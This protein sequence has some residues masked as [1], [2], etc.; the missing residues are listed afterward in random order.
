MRFVKIKNIASTKTLHEAVFVYGGA[1]A[2][3]GA[4]FALNV[5]LAHMLS[6]ENFGAFSLAIL[7]LG[8]VAELSDFGLNAGFLRFAPYY[9]ERNEVG[10]LTQLVKTV[11]RWRLTMSAIL[12]VGGIIFA[13][14]IAVYIFKQPAITGLLRLS[15]LGVGGVIL[16]GFV[17]TYLQAMQHFTLTSMLQ[18]LKGILRF[19][20]IMILLVCKVTNLYV[21][22]LAYLLIPW[23]LLGMLYH[24]LP[25]NFNTIKVEE[26]VKKKLHS[27]LARY[28]FWITIW[29]FSAIVSSRIDQILISN[30]LDLGQVAIYSVA[31]QFIFIYSL[32]IQSISSVLIPKISKITSRE[33][34]AAYSKKVFKWI[35]P[36]AVLLAFCIYPSQFVVSLIFGEKYAASM[37]L[38]T[39]LSYFTLVNFLAIPLPLI[40][41]VYN[42][43][44]LIAFSG[45]L[46][47]I[48]NVMCGL[49]FIPQY[50]VIGAVVAFGMGTVAVHLYS[51]CVVMYLFKKP[52]RQPV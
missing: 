19:L 50:G 42:R 18:G 2:N 4:L 36:V 32:A 40:I 46:Q 45:F 6:K 13:K 14:Y 11:W 44:D 21:L 26:D 30:F 25:K 1:L 9:R 16:L 38:Y 27:Q 22:I 52:P 23:I 43:T 20:I 15:F 5:V 48:I 35:V 34:L 39:Y 17:T 51:A 49:L 3:G 12:T 24:K 31:F 47:L 10:K 33:E 7:V 41:S 28:S 29:S 37:P 8:T